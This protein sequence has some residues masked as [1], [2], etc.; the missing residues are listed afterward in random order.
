MP[1]R[2]RLLDPAGPGGSLPVEA[3]LR[4]LL[5]GDAAAWTITPVHTDIDVILQDSETIGWDASRVRERFG[6]SVSL[7][8]PGD[9]EGAPAGN[10][11]DWWVEVSAAPS[12]AAAGVMPLA[13]A[14]L[15]VIVCLTA[16]AALLWALAA[17][18]SLPWMIAMGPTMILATIAVA[19]FTARRVFEVSA[20]PFERAASR[21]VARV[22]A[23]VEA[24]ASRAGSRFQ[25]ASW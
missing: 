16:Y 1:A 12:S 3:D 9:P 18:V 14:S 10:L 8:G 19:W 20:R 2:F 21:R 7:L 6:E 13:L 4:A 5:P 17:V 24:Q 15:V 23:E 11:D 22:A 25:L